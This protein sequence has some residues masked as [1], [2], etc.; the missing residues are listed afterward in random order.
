LKNCEEDADGVALKYN[1]CYNT[2]ALK[3]HNLKRKDHG[4]DDLAFDAV[5]AIEA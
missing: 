5:I 2:K 3:A 1:E 4:T